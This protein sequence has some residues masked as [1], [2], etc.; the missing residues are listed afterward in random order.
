MPFQ[1]AKAV[2]DPLVKKRN[3]QFDDC[4]DQKK[5]KLDNAGAEQQMINGVTPLF[6]VPYNEQV[7]NIYISTQVNFILII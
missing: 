1:N 3:E 6:N 5:I 2:P 7:R 4:P